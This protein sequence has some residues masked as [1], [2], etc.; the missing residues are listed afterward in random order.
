VSY[1][2]FRVR[3]RVQTLPVRM[4]L[5]WRRWEAYPEIPLASKLRRWFAF[6]RVVRVNEEKKYDFLREKRNIF[7]FSWSIP[8][9]VPWAS[10]SSTSLEKQKFGALL[11]LCG[12]R[13]GHPARPVWFIRRSGEGSQ[14]L[15]L[16]DEI[17]RNTLTRAGISKLA[18]VK[19]SKKR[20][21]G[22]I[23]Q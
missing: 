22:S 12:K 3:T 4:D 21:S 16:D 11:L 15:F 1:I 14:K 10:S 17:K 19:F 20:T 13:V 6:V 8:I 2:I 9:R 18:Q 7:L 23:G 5:R